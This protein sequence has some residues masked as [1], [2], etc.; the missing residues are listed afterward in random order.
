MKYYRIKK[1]TEFQKIFT[2]G[3]R[4][5][6][7]HLTLLYIP[8]DKF[9]MGICVSKKHGKSVVR[10]KIKRVLREIFRLNQDN[11]QKGYKYVLLPKV[12]EVY[13]YKTLEKDF[14]YIVKK[15]NLFLSA[16]EE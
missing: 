8:S 12:A 10:N 4:G 3:K 5:F 16:K 15:Q 9:S 6:S 13:D 7:A 2:K 14:L 11:L 1:N